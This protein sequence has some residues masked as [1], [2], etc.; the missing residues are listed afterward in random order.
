MTG[1]QIREVL[2]HSLTLVQGMAQVSGLRAVYDMRRSK[3]GRLVE[4]QIGGRPA[5][6]RKTYHVA[7]TSFIAEGGDECYT[8]MKSRPLEKGPLLSDVLMDYVRKRRV[9]TPPQTGRLVPLNEG[10]RNVRMSR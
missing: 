5:E 10:D 1:A 7:I 3:G 9:I 4:M 8:L 6:D 2:E